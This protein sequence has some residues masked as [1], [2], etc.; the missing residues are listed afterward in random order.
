MC[1]PG[2][3]VVSRSASETWAQ[4]LPPKWF[5]GTGQAAAALRA[6]W[7]SAL[8]VLCCHQMLTPVN[9]SPAWPSVSCWFKRLEYPCQKFNMDQDLTLVLILLWEPGVYTLSSLIVFWLG[10]SSAYMYKNV[11]M[12]K[13]TKKYVLR[14][15]YPF[16]HAFQRAASA[17]A[18]RALP[19]WWF[20]IISSKRVA[21]PN[22]VWQNITDLCGTV[23]G[24]C[25]QAAMT[26]RSLTMQAKRKPPRESTKGWNRSSC[27]FINMTNV[28][29]LSC[30]GTN[31]PA[32]IHQLSA[33]WW[34]THIPMSWG[35][36]WSCINAI[37]CPLLVVLTSELALSSDDYLS[38]GPFPLGECQE[39]FAT[40][41]KCEDWSYGGGSLGCW[42]CEPC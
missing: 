29:I 2:S 25:D 28:L 14:V 42:D 33:R 4:R 3:G 36:S 21:S 37:W 23:W 17:K 13:N 30:S 1:K 31:Q 12:Y 16:S 15:T 19:K 34:E 18:G 20:F 22:V 8:C 11:Y 39:C 7:A 24:A 35:T 38:A 9:S 41:T 26:D 5:L 40:W 10:A 32:G 27:A 6:R